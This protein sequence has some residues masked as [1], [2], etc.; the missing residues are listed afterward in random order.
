M[1]DEHTTRHE[2]IRQR[3]ELQRR[4][5]DL[6]RQERAETQ[7]DTTDTAHEWGNAELRG[8]EMDQAL[9][10]LRSVEQALMRMDQGGYGACGR[11]GK[12][13][14]DERLELLPETVLCAACARSNASGS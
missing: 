9:N 12:P 5:D 10:E 3:D 4:I 13:I 11:C 8:D 1:A 2:L 14:G 6:Q 7:D